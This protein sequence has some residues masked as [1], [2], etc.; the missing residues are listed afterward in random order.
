LTSILKRPESP[1]EEY[2]QQFEELGCRWSV[3]EA[4]VLGLAAKAMER[5]IGARGL[6][7]VLSRYFDDAL[8]EAATRE[9][10]LEVVFEPSMERAVVRPL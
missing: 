3:K 10:D 8:Y 5:T 9:G 2:R 1:L 6:D 4:G 7:F